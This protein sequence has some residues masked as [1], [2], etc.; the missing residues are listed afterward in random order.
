MHFWLF[1]HF[2]SNFLSILV[3]TCLKNLISLS[4]LVKIRE[5]LFTQMRYIY[6]FVLKWNGEGFLFGNG[7]ADLRVRNSSFNILITLPAN[8]NQNELLLTTHRTEIFLFSF[9][10]ICF[11]GLKDFSGTFLPSFFTNFF[12]YSRP[13]FNW[14]AVLGIESEQKSNRHRQAVDRKLF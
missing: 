4:I 3:W 9:R 12:V 7:V 5:I 10:M 1:Y 8:Q 13:V 2:K 11:P 6:K 14:R